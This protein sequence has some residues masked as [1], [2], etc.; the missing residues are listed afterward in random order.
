MKN[1][2]KK[3]RQKAEGRKWKIG[4]LTILGYLPRNTSVQ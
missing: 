2:D 1:R 4:L 3:L